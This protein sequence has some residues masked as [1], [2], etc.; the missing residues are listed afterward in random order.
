VN[1]LSQGALKQ[2]GGRG[3]AN[4]KLGMLLVFGSALIWSFGGV[5]ARYLSVDDSWTVVFWRSAWAALFLLAFM[6]VRDGPK[7]T[8]MLFRGMGLPGVAVA[9]CFATASTSFIVALSFTTVANILLLQAGVPLIAALIAWAVFGEKVA[10]ATWAAIAAVI[11]G[12]AVMMSDSL[13]GKVSPVGNALALL[14]SVA[15]AS[16]T[17]ITRRYS[18]VRMTPACCLGTAIAT[19]VSGVMAGQLAVGAGDMGLLFTFGALNLG[20]GLALFVT[21]A[22][23]VPAAIAALIGTLETIL[24]PVWVWIIHGETASER[25]IGGGTIVFLALI[26]HLGWQLLKNR[27]VMKTATPN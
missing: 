22:R 8:M 18:G 3:A 21:G 20:L 9:L 6:L 23:L 13:N 4:D 12:V 5:I 7:G 24:A 16:A 10:P 25:T 11:V 15:F 19:C 2:S 14:I 26:V 27:R 17:V 1:R